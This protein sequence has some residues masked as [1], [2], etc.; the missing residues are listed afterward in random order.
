MPS[1]NFND[2]N[3]TTVRT[4]ERRNLENI[5]FVETILLTFLV[6]LEDNVWLY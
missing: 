1:I 5:N 2:I 6:A 4:L 3:I